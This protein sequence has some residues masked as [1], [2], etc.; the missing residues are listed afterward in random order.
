MNL[1]ELLALDTSDDR[2]IQGLHHDSRQ[3]KLGDVFLAYPGEQCDGR[4]FIAKAIEAGAVAIVY[5]PRD[6]F[7]PPPTNVPCCPLP[8][9]STHLAA[10][11]CRF[12][13]NPSQSLC[14][15]GVTGTN[16]KTSIAYQLAQAYT[17]CGQAAAYI[18]TL[19]YGRVGDIKPL[20]NTTPDALL[21]QRILS[22]FQQ[23]HVQQVCME[24]SSHALTQQR[25][26]GVAFKQAIYTNLSHE[27]LDYHHTMDAYA[28]AKASLFAVPSL[29][30]VVINADDAYAQRMCEPIPTNARLLRYGLSDDC[31]VRAQHLSMSIVGSVFE[32]ITPQ[33]EALVRV[34]SLGTFNVYNS[35]AVMSS[36]LA[37]GYTLS[38]VVETMA[39]V[40]AAP[41]RMEIVCDKPSVIVDYA[42]TPDALDN[43]LSTVA[44]LN[45]KGALWV[46]FGCGGN[47]DPS[48]RPVMGQVA[49]QYATHV[50]VTNDNPRHEAP[51]SIINDILQ[52]GTSSRT[53][54]VILD[55]K[56]AILHALTHAQP[57]DTI[58][59]AGKG[60]EDYQIMGDER[61]HFS[62]Q[63]VVLDWVE[64]CVM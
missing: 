15:T 17:H 9:L 1:R 14:V 6:N 13:H 20:A 40:R 46:V 35:L 59:I 11:A 23:Q 7:A 62:D 24:V 43:V 26:E 28:R 22:L 4:Q 57:E 32:V 34:P 3:I 27:H 37:A 30:W 48:K 44:Q 10:L 39:Q 45:P 54:E 5:D 8:D 52:G 51:E 31:D 53:M 49:S 2:I 42:H 63:Q 36:L 12:Y 33:G 50:I 41:G 29:E 61:L 60:H 25:V 19:G 58:V 47:R 38:Q 21:V 56:T 16:G 18:G 55:R 64:S